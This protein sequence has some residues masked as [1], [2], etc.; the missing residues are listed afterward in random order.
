MYRKRVDGLNPGILAIKCPPRISN[1]S[2]VHSFSRRRPPGSAPFPP[3][4]TTNPM[5]LF[6]CFIHW[7]FF[8]YVFWVWRQRI[9]QLI[10]QTLFLFFIL[11]EIIEKNI[12]ILLRF[13]FLILTAKWK[14]F[15][16]KFDK[17]C[18]SGSLLTPSV[19]VR[20]CRIGYYY[21][22]I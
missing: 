6:F 19:R 16:M 17:R 15:R 10:T 8:D 12:D 11:L 3:I 14:Y 21:G 5:V 1:S 4:V 18:K 2:L 20:T 13:V 7:R 22:G 9:N